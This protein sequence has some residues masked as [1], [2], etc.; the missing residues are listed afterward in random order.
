MGLLRR[1]A[2]RLDPVETR[3]DGDPFV[4][5]P[6]L[7]GERAISPR[8][9]EN[10]STVLGCVQAIASGI[11]SLPLNVYQHTAAGKIEAED[12][13]LLRLV[14]NGPNENQSWP[15]FVE[16]WVAQTLLRGN[17]L[18]EVLR[19]G[20]GRLAE[21]KPVPWE[22]VSCQLLKNGRLA[23]DVANPGLFGRTG[24][25]RRLLASEVSHLRDRSDDGYVGRSRLQRAASVVSAALSTQEHSASLMLNS[26][27]PGGVLTAPGPLGK[28]T[29]T[30]LAGRW[31]SNYGAQNRG[32]IAVLGDGLKFE[33]MAFSPEDSE[34]LAT[35][36]FTTEELCR[37]YQV[38]PPVIGDLSNG[39]FT[40]SETAG[41]WFA[42]LTLTPWVRKLECEMTRSLL[43]EQSRLSHQIEIDL[44]GL[45]RGDPES[46]WQSHKIAIEAGILDAGEIREL[47]GWNPRKGNA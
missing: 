36:R 24:R 32:K 13:P 9:A 45:L 25:V 18:V 1:I 11:A 30:Q 14:R 19:D 12:H 44:S 16:W 17:G 42:T 28:D 43:S 26:A 22:S 39:S 47:E 29:A 4:G 8:L 5:I 23:Y 41:R 33:P 20:S 38:P 31:S 3:T 15:D 6:T 37:I 40:N 34:L 46:R 35:R 2:D 27:V 10:L 21:L 7:G